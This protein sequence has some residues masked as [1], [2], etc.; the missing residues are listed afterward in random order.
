MELIEFVVHFSGRRYFFAMNPALGWNKA[1]CCFL[2]IGERNFIAISCLCN[3]C[4]QQ[5]RVCCE[6]ML[7]KD[8]S[9]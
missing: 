9:C 7:T 6:L 4:H 3:M 2:K 5:I 1:V 8:L